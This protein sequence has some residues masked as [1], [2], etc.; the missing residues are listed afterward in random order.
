MLS[1]VCGAFAATG[2]TMAQAASAAVYVH[3]L[4]GD[5]CKKALGSYGTMAGDIA[6][7]VADALKM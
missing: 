6:N 2:M 7:A 5:A 1:G 3:G 4:A